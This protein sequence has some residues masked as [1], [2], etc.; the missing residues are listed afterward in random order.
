MTDTPF[1]EIDLDRI[2]QNIARMQTFADANSLHLRPHVKTHKSIDLA[3]QQLAAGA[4]GITVAT[5]GEAEVFVAA[6]FTD[7]FIAYPL[8]VTD[9][10][11]ARLNALT[12]HSRIIIG[13]DSN[14]AA[15]AGAARLGSAV[16][17]RIEIDSG[18][19]RSG[20]DPG[21]VVGLAEC[22]SSSNHSFDGLFTFPGH[23]YAPS[24]RREA[25][26]DEATTLATCV[27]KL[28]Q[29]GFT[30]ATVS[31]GSTPSVG[32][33]DATVVNEIRPGV[34]LFGDAQ[35]WELGTTPP[36]QIA[37]WAQATVVSR[38]DN[39]FVTDVGSKVLGADRAAYATGFG[40]LL[41][42]P[43]ARIVLLS[44]HHSVIETPTTPLPALGNRVRIVPNHVC[45]A[46]NLAATLHTTSGALV[47]V[48]ARGANA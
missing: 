37:L 45:N 13:V 38:R 27:D 31:G 28:A 25:A 22:I 35:Q 8:W 19:R 44:E 10:L 34:Y 30:V 23:A 14:E 7:V 21:H 20:I 15:T 46:V 32:F 41:D 29:A 4:T 18:H 6:G 9:S 48:D 36:E 40:R 5:V 33:S 1:L 24:G 16:E 12:E 2:E 43:E 17:Y 39:R 3:N 26:R 47:T 11:A 42:D